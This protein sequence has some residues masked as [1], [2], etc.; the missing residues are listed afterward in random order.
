MVLLIDVTQ[1]HFIVEDVEEK[2][3]HPQKIMDLSNNIGKSK[4]RSM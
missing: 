2:D 4:Y 1:P 3:I